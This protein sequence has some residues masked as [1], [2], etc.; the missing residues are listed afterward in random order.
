MNLDLNYE[1][2][3]STVGLFSAGLFYKDLRDF[4]YSYQ[5]DGT[6]SGYN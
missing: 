4:I 1:T 6:Y 3:F 5:Y 2:Y